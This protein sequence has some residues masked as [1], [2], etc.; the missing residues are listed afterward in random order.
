MGEF[1]NAPTD[2]ASGGEGRLT[3]P[4]DF[5]DGGAGIKS[6][7]ANL[8]NAGTRIG[9]RNATVDR[10]D[11]MAEYNRDVSAEYQRVADDTGFADQDALKGFNQ[12][13]AT[14]KA[15]LLAKHKAFGD[16]RSR[17]EVSLTDN[18]SVYEGK[19]VAAHRSGQIKKLTKG[20]GTSMQPIL[21]GVADGTYT[22]VDAFKMVNNLSDDLGGTEEQGFNLPK[23]MVFD[24]HDAAQSQVAVTVLNKHLDGGDWESGLAE[25][26][27]PANNFGQVLDQEQMAAI[28]KRIGKQRLA[29]NLAGAG[30]KIERNNKA[31]DLGFSKWADVPQNIKFALAT[32][33]PIPG[34]EKFT[35]STP[36]AKAAQD[37]IDFMRVHKDDVNAISLFQAN[38][39]QVALGAMS[40]GVGKLIHTKSILEGQG[41]KKGDPEYDA[42][43]SQIEAKDKKLMAGREKLEKLP[44]AQIALKTFTRRAGQMRDDAK[45]AV[46]LWT[47][48]KTYADALKVIADVKIDKNSLATGTTGLLSIASQ[49]YPGS[50][51]NEINAA[52]TRL[53]GSVLID[54]LAAL[55]NA[56]PTGSTGMGALNET[57]GNALRFQD[58]ALTI[59]APMTTLNS[60][61]GIIDNTDVAIVNQT[62][63]FDHAFRTVNIGSTPDAADGGTVTQA[64]P[65]AGGGEVVYGLTGK[66]VGD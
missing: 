59:D 53:G 37:E 51:I 65:V 64:K 25:L 58:G 14:K 10:V 7:A 32:N 56:S 55:K 6:A 16:S 39:K 29:H 17:L 5:G 50:D 38:K 63:F 19:A 30:A 26:E 13:S 66:P 61:I 8:H 36:A 15:E 60:L 43:V 41:M 3:S 1:F 44:A 18:N 47:G 62:R 11:M 49:Q 35:P 34:M 24:L 2:V 20:F 42:V 27:N 9:N 4:G 54:S 28:T 46:M 45:M 12:F 31:N 23:S 33:Q 21:D 22:A 48:T 40:E 57:E 52:L